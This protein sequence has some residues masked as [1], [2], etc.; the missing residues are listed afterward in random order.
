M[1]LKGSNRAHTGEALPDRWGI[2]HDHE[3]IA[4][5]WNID[6]DGDLACTHKVAA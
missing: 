1:E 2:T 5:R 6:P 4:R 3:E